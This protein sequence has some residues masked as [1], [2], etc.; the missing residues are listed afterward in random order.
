MKEWFLANLTNILVCLAL[1]G[2]VFLSVFARVKSRKKGK[3]PCG[4]NCACCGMCKAC[5]SQREV[6]HT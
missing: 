4:G 5:Q 3:S 2:I 6:K 1:G